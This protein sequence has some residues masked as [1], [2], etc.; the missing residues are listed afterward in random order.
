MS[1][2]GWRMVVQVLASQ[3]KRIAIVGGPRT[4]KTTLARAIRGRPIISTDDYMDLAWED[5]PDKVIQVA[6]AAG[7]SFVVEGVQAARALRKGLEVDAVVVMVHPKVE[8]TPGQLSMAKGV[9]TVLEDWQS[10]R[11]TAVIAVEP[12]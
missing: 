2:I 5:V 11:P 6:G 3:H 9:M 10:S 12:R 8:L 4:G 1:G 7:G